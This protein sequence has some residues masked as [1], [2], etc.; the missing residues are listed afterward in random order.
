MLTLALALFTP[1]FA[2]PTDAIVDAPK[3]TWVGIDYRSAKLYGGVFQQKKTDIFPFM[4]EKWNAMALEQLPEPL[5]KST[6]K[7]PIEIDIDHVRADC[8]SAKPETILAEGAGDPKTPT[9]SEAQVKDIVKTWNIKTKEG[10]GV[11]YVMDQMVESKVTTCFHPVFVDLATKD[12]IWTQYRCQ[13]T[14]GVGLPAWFAGILTGTE[15][16]GKDYKDWQKLR[17]VLP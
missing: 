11:G 13:E 2:A 14:G 9:L 1:A 15:S 10:I 7:K 12:V 3:L 4:L 8:E 17:T 16:L 6:G 5:K